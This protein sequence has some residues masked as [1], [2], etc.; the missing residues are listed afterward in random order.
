MSVTGDW[1]LH[2]SWACSSSY[3]QADISFNP[4]GTFGGLLPGKWVQ[5]D[6]TLLLSYDDGPAMYGGSIDGNVGS[7]AM[8]T[9]GGLNGCWYLTKQGTVGILAQDA[10]E[11]DRHQQSHDAAGNAR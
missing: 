10:Q 8:S 7:G 5:Q 4:N 3:A 2:Y 9:F 11:A 1:I 6:G